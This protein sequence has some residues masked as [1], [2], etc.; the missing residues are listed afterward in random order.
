MSDP[1]DQ[2]TSSF[3]LYK[4]WKSHTIIS[5]IMYW[6]QRPAGFSIEGDDGGTHRPRNEGH[7]QLFGGLASTEAINSRAL[8]LNLDPDLGI[9]DVSIP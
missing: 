1:R 9:F 2:D 6:S 3:V 4:P 8:S 5:A 7:W